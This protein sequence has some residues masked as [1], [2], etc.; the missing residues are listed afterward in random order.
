MTVQSFE[1]RIP[2][3]TLDDLYD[4]LATTRLVPDDDAKDW[5]AGMSPAY[6][7][8][9]LDYWQARY[10]WR[11]RE[12]RIN[13]LAQF[14]AEVGGTTL[15][16]VHE[17]GRG[18]APLPIVLTHGYPD[19]FLRF[20][21]LIP[22]LAD[23]AAHGGDAR[24]AFH[25][26][27]PSLPGY[28]FSGKSDRS[29]NTFDIGDLW[30]KLMAEELGYKAFVAHGGDW[31]STVTEHLARSYSN[32]VIAIHLTDVPF[33][34]S[35]QKPHDPSPAEEALIAA[36]AQ[37]QFREGAYAAI[38]GTRPLTLAEGLNDSP[39]GLAAWL[40]EKFQRWSDCDGDVERRFTKDE[41]LDNVMIYWAT[42]TI[43]SSFLPY[44]DLMHAGAARWILEKAKEW[45]GST[46]VPAGFALFPRDLGHPPLEWASRFFNV[47]GWTEMPRGGHFAAMEEPELLAEDI[48]AFF[49]PFR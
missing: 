11:A 9:L 16:F 1:V 48:R 45:V 28:A 6:L 35:F 41:L 24:D 40:V 18:E 26:V 29:G 39:L 14:R 38:Q 17:R 44:Y 47:Q 23:P 13:E 15:H 31:G 22:L 42:Q 33:W 36:N 30:Y 8:Q 43:G 34:H 27:V 12:S 32:A 10:D 19:S 49:R 21:K 25:V 3:S 20:M 2:D 5:D 37:F 4:R 46:K 7:Q